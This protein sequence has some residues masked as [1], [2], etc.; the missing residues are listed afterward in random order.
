MN[1]YKHALELF[2]RRLADKDPL[3]IKAS[4]NMSICRITS[5]NRLTFDY[6]D[7]IDLT[8]NNYTG[9]LA[10]SSAGKTSTEGVTK[11]EMK[12]VLKRM[13]KRIEEFGK[14]KGEFIKDNFSH[15]KTMPA[16]SN[17]TGTKE[18]FIWDRYLYFLAG[19][20]CS[21]SILDEFADHFIGDRNRVAEALIKDCY[22]FGNNTEINTKSKTNG[23]IE[24]VPA[25]AILMT[26]IS[27][28]QNNPQLL[29]QFEKFLSLGMARRCFWLYVEKAPPTEESKDEALERKQYIEENSPIISDYYMDLYDGTLGSFRKVTIPFDLEHD[30]VE[31]YQ[32]KYKRIACEKAGLWQESRCSGYDGMIWKV[33]KL[34]CA[35]Q[36]F[37]TPKNLVLTKEVFEFALQFELDCQRNFLNFYNTKS[38]LSVAEKVYLR[39]KK[40]QATRTQIFSDRNICKSNL[41]KNELESAFDMVGDIC[42]EN[43]EVLIVKEEKQGRGRPKVI[44]CIEP[45]NKPLP[46]LKDIVTEK[47]NTEIMVSVCDTHTPVEQSTKAK[48]AIVDIYDFAK[49]L[50]SENNSRPYMVGHCVKRCKKEHEKIINCVAFDIDNTPDIEVFKRSLTSE[51]EK[52]LKDKIPKAKNGVQKAYTIQDIFEAFPERFQEIDTLYPKITIEEMEEVL[53]GLTYIIQPSKSHMKDKSM[54]K[55][56]DRFHGI[57]MLS[58]PIYLGNSE[59]PTDGKPYQEFVLSL[60]KILGIAEFCDEKVAT[61]SQLLYRSPHEAKVVEGNTLNPELI[62]TNA[63]Q[64]KEGVIYKPELAEIFE[65]YSHL[66]RGESERIFCPLHSQTSK[67][68]A[69]A[70]YRDEEGFLNAF[71]HSGCQ[72]HKRIQI[73]QEF[74]NAYRI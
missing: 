64:P 52:E 28:F 51:Q 57:I 47:E 8:T 69:F 74:D 11:R 36:A 6:D 14:E 70:I 26:A 30:I 9:I 31:N 73:S 21:Y 37:E 7:A 17:T 43:D 67:A 44:Y 24:G 32:K 3:L 10:P 45:I 20:G 2:T 16:L 12:P 42:S 35:L 72:G 27:D 62:P 53:Q 4:L 46:V 34:A 60:Y 13:G 48:K 59:N 15:A 29:A 55:A 33:M 68:P 54:F 38:D 41:R 61:L 66:K 22:D 56:R 39:L 18:G 63:R 49:Y 19:F 58:E 23:N 40:G 1:K 5:F 25:N 65:K 50:Q 71:C